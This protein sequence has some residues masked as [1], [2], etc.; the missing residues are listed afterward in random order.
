MIIINISRDKGINEKLYTSALAV[1]KMYQHMQFHGIMVIE[2]RFFKKKKNC[3]IAFLLI[4]H[5]T[6]NIFSPVS[7]YSF[8][9]T[10]S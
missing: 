5:T 3:N 10:C 4:S 9:F 6:Y 7:D 8:L 2:F 1:M